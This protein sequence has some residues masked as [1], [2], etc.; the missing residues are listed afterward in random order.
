MPLEGCEGHAIGEDA[1]EFEVGPYPGILLGSSEFDKNLQRYNFHRSCLAQVNVQTLV[2][3][4]DEDLT[5]SN[6]ELAFRQGCRLH[7]FGYDGA[8]WRQQCRQNKHS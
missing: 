6:T 3:S 7:A 4:T 1:V 2:I 5:R 8:S